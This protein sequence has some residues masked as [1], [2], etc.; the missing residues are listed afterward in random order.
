MLKVSAMGVLNHCNPGFQQHGLLDPKGG[1]ISNT[2]EPER[3]HSYTFNGWWFR[4]LAPMLV[5]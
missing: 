1:F 4:V 5:T 3:T 2:F